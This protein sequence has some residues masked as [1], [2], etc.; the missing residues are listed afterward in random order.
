[1][2]NAGRRTARWGWGMISAA[3]GIALWHTGRATGILSVLLLSVV[4]V[5]GV[6]VNQKGRLTG[7]PRFA[8]SGLHRNISLLAVAFVAVHVLTAVVDPSVTISVAAVFVPF[9]SAYQRGWI[10]LGAVSIDLFAAVTI[11][12][13]VRQRIGQRTWLAIHWLAYAAWPVALI[14]GLGIAT[15]LH[16]AWGLVLTWGCVAGVALAVTWRLTAA[17]LAVPRGDH[18]ASTISAPIRPAAEQSSRPGPICPDHLRSAEC[19]QS[20]RT[21]RSGEWRRSQVPLSEDIAGHPAA[22]EQAMGPGRLL[23][24]CR[25]RLTWTSIF[26]YMGPCHTRTVRD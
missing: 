23:P 24:A 17:V 13:L 26:T 25:A 15:D 1:M 21:G 8:L 9:V 12:S 2:P 7:L 18:R 16:S 10:G 5:L 14:H 19:H 11:T 6:L 20:G 22:G 3:S 4:I